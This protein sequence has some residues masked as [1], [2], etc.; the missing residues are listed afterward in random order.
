M[1]DSVWFKLLYWGVCVILALFWIALIQHYGKYFF[2]KIK[3][4]FKSRGE[5]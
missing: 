3:E 5:K 1:S 2:K 4:K